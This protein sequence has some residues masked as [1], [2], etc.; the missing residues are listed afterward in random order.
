MSDYQSK[1]PCGEIRLGEPQPVAQPWV[2]ISIMNYCRRRKGAPL[3]TDAECR[4]IETA[5]IQL[6]VVVSQQEDK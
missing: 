1:N 6:D 2:Q 3:L 4:Q 5:F